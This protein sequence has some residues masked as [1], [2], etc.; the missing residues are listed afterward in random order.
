MFGHL[1]KR[2]QGDLWPPA[3]GGPPSG[4]ERTAHSPRLT[5]TNGVTRWSVMSSFIVSSCM[6]IMIDNDKKWLLFIQSL[7]A[8][9][10]NTHILPRLNDSSQ[11]FLIQ[12]FLWEIPRFPIDNVYNDHNISH[13]I[14]CLVLEVP[15]MPWNLL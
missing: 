13:F 12:C 14:S 5:R 15:I 2:F 10:C 11:Y 6:N 7:W 4:Q 8:V 1:G 3:L 9:H